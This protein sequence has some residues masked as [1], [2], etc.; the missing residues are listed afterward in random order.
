MI[1]RR[2]WRKVL[3]YIV[4]SCRKEIYYV[5]V[6]ELEN[7]FGKVQ[8][9]LKLLRDMGYIDGLYDYSNFDK[10]YPTPKGNSYFE[11][12]RDEWIAFLHK[13]VL[14]PMIVALFSTHILP[15]FFTWIKNVLGSL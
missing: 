8:P 5:E 13:S 10:V 6:A 9:T 1:S 14:I 15:L 12:T 11:Y 2:Y 4:N 7:K 3:K